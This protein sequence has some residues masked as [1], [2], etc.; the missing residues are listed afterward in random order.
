M[1]YCLIFLLIF[2][3]SVGFAQQFLTGVV[4]DE[5]DNPIPFAQVYVKNSAELRTVAD[6]FGAYRVSLFPGEYFLVV[7]AIGF[8]TREFYE[9]MKDKPIQR[10]IQLFPISIKELEAV[11]VVAKKSN[12]GRDI[13]LRVVERREQI[14][15]WNYPHRVEGYTRATETLDKKQKL[16]KQKETSETSDEEDPFNVEKKQRDALA[17]SMNLVEVQFTRD[18]APP[19]KVKE[20]RNAYEKRGNDVNLYYT[21]TVKSNFNFFE[22]LLHLDDL[23]Q[24]PVSS[25]ISNPGIL[26]YK[27]RL[28]E[29]Y[30][31]QGKLISRIKIIPRNSSTSTLSGYIW[32]IDSVWLVQKIEL[33][34]SKGNLLKY[35]YFTIKQRFDTPGDSMC[36]LTEQELI[37]GVKYKDQTSLC[38]TITTYSNYDFNYQFSQRYFNTEVAVTEQEAYDRDSTFW[39]NSRKVALTVEEQKYIVLKDSI[40]AYQ[41]R[42][43][44]LD[45]IDA[46]FNKLTIGKALWFGIDHRNRANKSQW[47]F[48]SLA[49]FSRPMYIAGPRVAPSFYY[50][51]KWESEQFIDSY[52]EFSLGVLNKDPKGRMWLRWRYDPMHIGNLSLSFSHEFDAIRSY[53]AITQIYK[54]ENFIE[55]TQGRIG[56]N[57]E[58]LN[59]LYLDAQ[60]EFSERRSIRD[61]KFLT[62]LDASLPNN[63]PTEFNTYQAFISEF[64]LN[65]T[66]EQRYM[67]EPKR[68]VI[69][70][71]RF[72]TFYITYERGLPKFMG[73]DVDHEYLRGGIMQT[74]KLG[75]LGTTSY[76][77]L[78]GKFLSARNLMMADFKFQR[79]SDPIWFSNPLYSFQGLDSS[80]PSKDYFLEAHLVHH[81]NSALINKIPFMKKTGVGLVVGAGA[82]Y[83]HEFDFT[84]VELLGGLERN[85]KFSRR[86]LRVGFYGVIS[87]NNVS[88]PRVNYKISFAVLDDRNMKWNF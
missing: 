12:P 47:T 70:G 74:F 4:K 2:S 56:N 79:R 21:T 28:E 57:V 22:N 48:S 71:S 10:D 49:A 23:H 34:L 30:E 32:V 72:P 51:K 82:L 61:Y 64:S 44:Y 86:R 53:D 35:D 69:L 83:V 24:S 33:T 25:P 60:L 65:Y 73:S 20:I 58:L 67:R 17:S 43:E 3:S 50:F 84:H 36:V 52:T 41:N 37:Y 19:I 8:Q 46:Q 13:M 77:V 9:V 6:E 81:D 7:E 75:T 55:S 62:G 11:Q 85:F 27:Y 31:E 14:N 80:L 39:T 87:D 45:S 54:R 15:L 76:H 88:S 66:P 1:R 5:M 63:L 78:S 42:K 29:K 40:E 59:G 38:K 26:S 16:E 68:K 18:F